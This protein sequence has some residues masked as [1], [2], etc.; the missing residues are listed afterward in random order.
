MA[1]FQPLKET[2]KIMFIAATQQMST[3]VVKQTLWKKYMPYEE[4]V[5]FRHTVSDLQPAMQ[6][7]NGISDVNKIIQ[8]LHSLTTL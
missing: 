5:A 7:F 4:F 1:L 8:I 3:S 2:S 6:T